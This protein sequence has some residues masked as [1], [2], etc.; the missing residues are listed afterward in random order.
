MPRN[1]WITSAILLSSALGGV[2]VGIACILLRAGPR[3]AGAKWWVVTA[4]SI[5]CGISWDRARGGPGILGGALGGLGSG[6]ALVG[7]LLLHHRD[8]YEILGELGFCFSG[9]W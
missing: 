7:L 1:K 6:V 4:P 5:A 3:E 2:C 8:Q 9:A